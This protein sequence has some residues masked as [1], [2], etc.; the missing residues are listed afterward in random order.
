M[1]P[2]CFWLKLE[3]LQWRV[4]LKGHY[5]G[6]LNCRYHRSRFC[7]IHP[8][9]SGVEDAARQDREE[10]TESSATSC[11]TDT[12][13]C[14]L[15]RLP[16]SPPM[17]H[18]APMPRKKKPSENDRNGE[19]SW[20]NL[21]STMFSYLTTNFLHSPSQT[22]SN[23]GQFHLLLHFQTMI[24]SQAGTR[25]SYRAQVKWPSKRLFEDL[26][27]RVLLDHNKTPDGAGNDRLMIRA[28]RDRLTDSN[29][30]IHQAEDQPAKHLCR[31]L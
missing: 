11:S 12:V 16:P 18:C 7:D 3:Q 4:W 28:K 31:K 6:Q 24:P 10:E 13:V 21:Q 20:V 27:L 14:C 25:S 17:L 1:Q 22:V 2:W 23:S 19:R 8:I 29:V 26:V 15:P 5:R 9:G 30:N